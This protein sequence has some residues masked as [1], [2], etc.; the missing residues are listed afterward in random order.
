MPA[1][2]LFLAATCSMDLLFARLLR[3]HQEHETLSSLGMEKYLRR[4]ASE[5]CRAPY[6]N[7]FPATFARLFM[8]WQENQTAMCEQNT[9]QNTTYTIQKRPCMNAQRVKDQ[10]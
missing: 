4:V 3:K 2:D 9:T 8:Q 5:V 6:S 1:R 10:V 7:G